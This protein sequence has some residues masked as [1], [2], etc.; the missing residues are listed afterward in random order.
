MSGYGEFSSFVRTH[1]PCSDLDGG[2][3]LELAKAA[4][5]Y[6]GGLQYVLYRLHPLFLALFGLAREQGLKAGAKDGR[7]RKPDGTNN[8]HV[9]S[10]M[11]CGAEVAPSANT[12]AWVIETVLANKKICAQMGKDLGL[13][14]DDGEPRSLQKGDINLDRFEITFYGLYALTGDGK[15]ETFGFKGRPSPAVLILTIA[16]FLERVQHIEDKNVAEKKTDANAAN[17]FPKHKDW[18]TAKGELDIEHVYFNYFHSTLSWEDMDDL[19]MTASMLA[20]IWSHVLL[21]AFKVQDVLLTMGGFKPDTCP[22]KP[23]LDAETITVTVVPSVRRGDGRYMEIPRPY[24]FGTGTLD[25]ILERGY[26]STPSAFD[27]GVWRRATDATYQ[28]NEEAALTKA[29][30][31]AEDRLKVLEAKK[32]KLDHLAELQAKAGKAEHVVDA[33]AEKRMR[34]WL[35]Q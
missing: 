26:T 19:K 12:V 15:A 21:K 1:D 16:Q 3:S 10:V 11:A 17:I 4:G 27:T 2:I 25:A 35:E 22:V 23:D 18:I 8:P 33:A 30:K 20:P 24:D 9:T 31:E 34:M 32:A 29:I 5:L 14:G 28:R 6:T 13:R 7:P